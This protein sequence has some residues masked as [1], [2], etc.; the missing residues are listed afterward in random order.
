MFPTSADISTITSRRLCTNIRTG[1]DVPNTCVD[2]SLLQRCQ[3]QIDRPPLITFREQTAAKVCLTRQN[4][5]KY[6]ELVTGY[7]NF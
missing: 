2:F 4:N 5:S 7:T 1:L 6:I 3:F